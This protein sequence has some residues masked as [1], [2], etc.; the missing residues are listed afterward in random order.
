MKGIII[1]GVGGL[2]TVVCEGKFYEG[3]ARGALRNKKIKPA[4]GDFA[5]IS[6]CDDGSCIIDSIAERKN[7]LL[8]P[9]VANIDCCVIVFAAKHPDLSFN[10]LDR[11]LIF[12]EKESIE[13]ICICI[14]KC[15]IGE[16]ETLERVKSIYGGIYGL[17]FVS[18]CENTGIRELRE[19]LTGKVSVLA[20]P[21]GVGKSS[22]INRILPESRLKTGDISRKIKRGR[23]TTRHTELLEFDKDSYVMDSPGF[24]S[25]DT[26]YLRPEELKNYFIEFKPYLSGCYFNDCRHIDEPRCR[27]KE[28]VGKNISAERYESFKALYNEV[29]SKYKEF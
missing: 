13:D 5:E 2:Y 29:K 17:Y 24:S 22:I 12:A 3:R 15:D 27:L 7:R 9:A 25:L 6:L 4:I 18:A 14:N 10:M 23:H 19:R 16:R 8:R 1:K 26:E 20:G 21:S 11:F 28:Q